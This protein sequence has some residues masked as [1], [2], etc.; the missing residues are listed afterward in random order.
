M[1][2]QQIEPVTIARGDCVSMQFEIVGSANEAINVSEY[3]AYYILSP[4]SFED[5]NVLWKDM[6]LVSGSN[7]IIRVT[8]LSS[9]T[10]TLEEGTYTA[11]IVLEHEGNFYKKAR[12]VFNVQKDTD[13]MG[14]TM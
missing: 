9:E 12:G 8:L 13:I 14:V 1:T 7:N 11:K 2:I 3:N 4:Y 5:E 10:A 6:S